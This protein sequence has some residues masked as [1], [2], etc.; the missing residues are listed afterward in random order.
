MRAVI[1]LPNI[2]SEHQVLIREFPQRCQRFRLAFRLRERAE[3]QRFVASDGLGNHRIDERRTRRKPER[4]E[5][6][7]LVGRIR[8]N[9]PLSERIVAF[10]CGEGQG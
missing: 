1:T 9:V 3:R 2:V 10:E 5:H 4:F 7:V 6:G 8:A